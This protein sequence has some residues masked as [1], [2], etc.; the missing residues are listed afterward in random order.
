MYTVDRPFAVAAYGAEQWHYDD[1]S[2]GYEIAVTA[3]VLG[4]ELQAPE[5]PRLAVFGGAG[6]E[7]LEGEDGTERLYGGGGDMLSAGA[8]YL[9]ELVMHIQTATRVSSSELTS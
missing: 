5:S 8:A 3:P 1:K 7:A 6:A 2:L 4:F 9:G